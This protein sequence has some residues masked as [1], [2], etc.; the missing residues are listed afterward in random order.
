MCRLLSTAVHKHNENHALSYKGPA[1]RLK[2]MLMPQI[3]IHGC[4]LWKHTWLCTPTE[5][6]S[7]PEC[8]CRR[9]IQMVRAHVWEC[10]D[11]QIQEMHHDALTAPLR[12]FEKRPAAEYGAPP[13]PPP[14]PYKWREAETEREGG[15]GRPDTVNKNTISSSDMPI[16]LE[17]W[18]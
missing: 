2:H 10:A 18:L 8:K 16:L 12:H 9:G 14:L 6:G 15:Q 11:V 3:Y 13:P 4:E 7:T 5:L 17:A 1:S